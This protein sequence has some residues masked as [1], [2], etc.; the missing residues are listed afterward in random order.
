MF[1]LAANRALP[2]QAEPRQVFQDRGLE[3]RLATDGVDILD[4]Q[5]ETPAAP[6]GLVVGGQD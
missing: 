4:A 3:P 6:Q 1:G 2:V 5:E